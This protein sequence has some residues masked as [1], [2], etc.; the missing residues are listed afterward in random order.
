L[1]RTG[2]EVEVPKQHL[3]CGRPLYD[4]G[5]LDMA[6][7]YLH[8][9]MKALRPQIDAGTP[10][11]V[12]EPSCASVFRDELH[13]LFPN[14]DTAQRLR[15]QVFLLSEFLEQKSPH[16]DIPQL[17]RDALIQGHCHHK[18]VLKLDDEK[19]I[20]KK[21][22]LECDF[23][24]SGCCGM[25]GSFGFEHDKYEV[26]VDIGERRLLPKVREADPS[27]LIIADGFSCREQIGQLSPRNALHL[28]EV[29]DQAYSDKHAEI[30]PETNI[31]NARKA[32]RRKARWQALGILLG[33]GA[34]AVLLTRRNFKRGENNGSRD[35]STGLGYSGRIHSAR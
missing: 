34:G 21:L 12:L 15:S 1:D 9:V 30:Y 2:F 28:A 8:R 10:I 17:S 3:C 19:A 24:T 32:S 31:V 6:K 22:A 18:S 16:L 7:Q 33:I 29:I 4:F 20:L 23:L 13:N 27:T 11:V 5:M 35:W 14:D 26:S 25:A